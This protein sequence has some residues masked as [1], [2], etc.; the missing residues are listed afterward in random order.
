MYNKFFGF[1]LAEVLI[2]M[3]I[4]GVVA[5]LTIAVIVPKF[6]E[7]TYVHQFKVAYS[8]LQNAYTKI[9]SED[10]DFQGYSS[11]EELYEKF[12]PQL[13]VVE[14]C[15]KT[16][17]CFPNITYDTLSNHS[18]YVNFYSSLCPKLRLANGI[19]VAFGNRELYVDTN[20]DKGPNKLGI[21]MFHF[22]FQTVK[23][24]LILGYGSENWMWESGFTYCD[25]SC[26]TAFEMHPGASCTWWVI[27]TGNMDYLHRKISVSEWR[28]YF[29]RN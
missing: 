24:T 5:V 16:E 12:L 15:F 7:Y 19:L 21:D 9:Q 1:T 22:R 20:G 3:G 25:I 2:T 4:I 26:K 27:K 18:K 11:A 6:K 28:K 14:K 8:V 23:P 13:K 17:G 29:K 10:G